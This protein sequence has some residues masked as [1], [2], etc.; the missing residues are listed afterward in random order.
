M[1]DIMN[2]VQTLELKNIIA[3]IQDLMDGFDSGME[4]AEKRVSKL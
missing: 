2:Q 1:Q 3:E 4:I